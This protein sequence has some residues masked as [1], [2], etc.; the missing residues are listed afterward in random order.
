MLKDDEG[1]Q[2]WRIVIPIVL[3]GL[4][5]AQGVG[6]WI[7]NDIKQSVL[8]NTQ[9]IERVSDKLYDHITQVKLRGTE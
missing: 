2:V 8:R 9:S 1:S 5:A 7:L 3:S 6:L 4:T